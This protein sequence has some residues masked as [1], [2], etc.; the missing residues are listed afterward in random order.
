M[1]HEKQPILHLDY[2]QNQRL[3]NIRQSLKIIFPLILISKIG[4]LLFLVNRVID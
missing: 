2:K 4:R 1:T 3:Q